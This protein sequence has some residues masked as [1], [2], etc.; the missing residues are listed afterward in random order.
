M[1]KPKFQYVRNRSVLPLKKSNNNLSDS[2]DSTFSDEDDG[3]YSSSSESLY[4]AVESGVELKP[5]K[6]IVKPQSKKF[7]KVGDVKNGLGPCGPVGSNGIVGSNGSNSIKD[8]KISMQ[9][10][11]S[12]SY[13][14]PVVTSTNSNKTIV[15]SKVINSGS[16]DEY[17]HRDLKPL[18]ISILTTED[19]PYVT[20][21]DHLNIPEDVATVN[22]V[23][24]NMDLLTAEEKDELPNI[25][26]IIE[27]IKRNEEITKDEYDTLP[28]DY[29][30]RL[31]E[32]NK[33]ERDLKR[34]RARKKLI[35]HGRFVR[36]LLSEQDLINKKLA[37]TRN[38][39][40]ITNLRLMLDKINFQIDDRKIACMA[41]RKDNNMFDMFNM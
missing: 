13:I 24:I 5:K 36:K 14:G 19:S 1:S 37:V 28:F 8:K 30:T 16:T 38:K 20:R 9:A 31:Y 17:Y 12:S 4:Y 2:D 6:S 40:E 34:E 41:L 39:T 11:S 35:E 26:D 3:A 22:D 18:E 32:F 21:H 10:S 27:R 29:K 33:R 23:T 25:L 15:N 7:V